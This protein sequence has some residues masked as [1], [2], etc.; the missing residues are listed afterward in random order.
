MGTPQNFPAEVIG[1]ADKEANA[2]EGQITSGGVGKKIQKAGE[3]ANMSVARDTGEN[4][5]APMDSKGR[6]KNK[7]KQCPMKTHQHHRLV[8]RERRDDEKQEPRNPDRTGTWQ[9]LSVNVLSQPK[10]Q[11]EI[12]DELESFLHVM[13][14]CA[15]RYLPHTC[16]NVGDFMYNFFDDG[17]RKK[18]SEYTCGMLKHSVMTQAKLLTLDHERIIFLR[19]PR[20]PKVK[21]VSENTPISDGPPFESSAPSGDLLSNEPTPDPEPSEAD[22]HPINDIITD[23]LHWFAARYR[24]QWPPS[25]PKKQKSKP[26]KPT[27]S[28]AGPEVSNRWRRIIGDIPEEDLSDD[29]NSEAQLWPSQAEVEKLAKKVKS[30]RPML[31]LLARACEGKHVVWPLGSEDKLADQLDSEYSPHQ[32]EKA[33][34][35]RAAPDD[36]QDQPGSK[37]R[38]GV[39]SQQA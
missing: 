21:V 1:D 38:R 18:D 24:L 17:V 27:T 34:D 31:V 14:Y 20:P 8:V 13:I 11:V 3:G 35:K 19:K 5:K 25:G 23:L 7:Q 28:A 22:H 37:R 33:R 9:F 29:D 4:T 32:A 16:E 2:A 30:H 6:A 36:A 15:I 26:V 39:A 12:A 10:A